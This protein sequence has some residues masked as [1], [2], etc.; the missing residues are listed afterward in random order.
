[1]KQLGKQRVNNLFTHLRK[2]AQHPLLV[3]KLFTDAQVQRL[4]TIAHQRQAT[5][6]CHARLLLFVDVDIM[7]PDAC[8]DCCKSCQQGYSMYSSALKHCQCKFNWVFCW[9]CHCSQSLPNH[10]CTMRLCVC[11][12]EKADNSNKA[13]TAS[14]HTHPVMLSSFLFAG[15][16]ATA[17]HRRDLAHESLWL[18]KT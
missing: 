17:V 8:Q 13:S 6:L 16:S 2:I 18:P 3:R 11:C 4:V 10:P 5:S 1:M 7:L 14:P 9:V 15:F 12:E